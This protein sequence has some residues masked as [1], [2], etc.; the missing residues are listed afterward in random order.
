MAMTFMKSLSG[1]IW[2]WMALFPVASPAAV[3][4]PIEERFQTE[5]GETMR[6]VYTAGDPAV[7][8]ETLRLWLRLRYPF[9]S[10][11]FPRIE[12]GI[13]SAAGSSLATKVFAN[14]AAQRRAIESLVSVAPDDSVRPLYN[15]VLATFE[16]EY[17]YSRTL[18]DFLEHKD[19]D[20]F[21]RMLDEKMKLRPAEK[22]NI[23]S[24]AKALSA[25]KITDDLRT[26]HEQFLNEHVM[27]DDQRRHFADFH[28]DFIRKYR[29][30][31]DCGCVEK[32]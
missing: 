16:R 22:E 19:A 28:R 8:D 15:A 31:I 7:T 5:M 13:S 2:L 9:E 29:I 14:L 3:A 23:L 27:V 1:M 12:R 4:E 10:F 21:I 25:G 6:C 20:R 32:C 30:G 11:G 17:A 18:A 26:V 24:M